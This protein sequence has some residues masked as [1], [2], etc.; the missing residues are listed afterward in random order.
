MAE[1]IAAKRLVVMRRALLISMINAIVSGALTLVLGAPGLQRVPA[2]AMYLAVVTVGFGAVVAAPRFT[3]AA[4]DGPTSATRGAIIALALFCATALVLYPPASAI[5]FTAAGPPLIL[6]ILVDDRVALTLS[7]ALVGTAVAV[8]AGAPDGPP[9]PIAVTYVPS[10]LGTMMMALLPITYAFAVTRESPSRV[11][12]WRSGS[13]SRPLPL[14]SA[15]AHGERV[16][17]ERLEGSRAQIGRERRQQMA[18]VAELIRAGRSY[19]EIGAA[20]GLTVHQVEY[21]A[22]RLMRERGVAT[23]GALRMELNAAETSA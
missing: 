18:D 20:L 23:K 9:T 7:A 5:A 21:V 17:G 19:G 4:K 22:R 6:A 16:G 1:R 3:A 13:G 12:A 8:A 11:A 10:M 14:G 15:E 2:A